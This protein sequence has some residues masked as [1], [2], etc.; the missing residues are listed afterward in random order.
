MAQLELPNA[1]NRLQAN[2][3][4]MDTFVNGGASD[5]YLTTGGEQVPSIQNFMAQKD[6]EIT[7]AVTDFNELKTPSGASGVGFV[8]AGTG[9]VTR[10]VLEK[11]RDGV[12]V[13]DYVS[14]QAALNTGKVVRLVDGVTYPVTSQTL[15]PSGGGIVGKGIFTVSSAD[16]AGTTL[17]PSAVTVP[18]LALNA[19]D[20]TLADFKIQVTATQNSVI[21]P[22]ALRGVS[23]AVVSDIEVTGL[24]GGSAIKIDSSTDIT[25][26][27]PYIH[28]CILDRLGSSGQLTG[29]E[30]DNDKLAG[31]G[32]QRVTVSNPKI[33]DLTV[34]PAFLAVYGYQ[35]DGVNIQVGAMS[36]S[37]FGGVIENVGEGI[38][39]FGDDGV[40]ADTIIKNPYIF[41]LKLV[42]GASRNKFSNH[43]IINPG[44]AGVTVAGSSTA[45]KN[46]DGN[47]IS[48]AHVSG[49]NPNGV[50]N[51]DVTYAFGTSNNGT[52]V[53]TNTLF[54][55]CRCTDS[56]GADY[57]VILGSTGN[58]NRAVDCE[59]D[60]TAA[61]Y[62]SVTN[63]TVLR[64]ESVGDGGGLAYVPGGSA[65]VQWDSTNIRFGGIASS[66]RYL[67]I[68]QFGSTVS[69][70]DDN[71][72][73]TLNSIQNYGV[74]A[75]G[76][77][78]AKLYQFG[79]A[80]VLGGNAM[81]E[82]VL[83]TDTWASPANRSA[84]YL[85]SLS[86]AGVTVP[87]IEVHP[88]RGVSVMTLGLGFRIKEGANAKQGIATLTA[89]T[90]VVP[91]TS[92]TLQSRIQ[93]TAQDNNTTGACRVSAIAA[94]VSFTITSNNASDSGV[95]AYQISEPA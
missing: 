71:G 87:V 25:I 20:I 66:T 57:V 10:S 7:H 29:V 63:G 38:D 56:P 91:N 33:R 76:H 23:K 37:V 43:R 18:F 51:T 64:R 52:F 44:L 5:S 8:Q 60:G 26:D 16:F 40:F 80:G 62:S 82:Q 24:N 68:S 72:A 32:S 21:Y 59:S 93:L 11:L 34:T 70:Y 94:G 50:W 9:T 67:D 39:T 4:R 65:R 6:Q 53:A 15:I 83:S 75:V 1:I 27:H 41:G 2:E 73:T 31:L 49:V 61:A 69:R 22:I 89:G 79:A 30:I 46:T 35:T 19:S 55:K 36:C 85:L 13:A 45:S 14:L 47:S 90:V 42:H 77:G 92:V 58:G 3:D 84:R 74:T 17:T 78:A 81:S 54:D 86:Q 95:V 48:G 88:A 12:S 28:D